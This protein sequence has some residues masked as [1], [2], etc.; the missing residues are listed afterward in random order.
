MERI[1]LGNNPDELTENEGSASHTFGESRG[2]RKVIAN[3]KLEVMC[4]FIDLR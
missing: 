4:L 3:A 2:E 1:L